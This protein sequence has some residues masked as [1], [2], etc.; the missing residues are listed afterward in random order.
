M[1]TF[2]VALTLEGPTGESARVDALVDTGST[3]AVIPASL[4]DRLGVLRR[5]RMSFRLADERMVDYDLGETVAD[6]DGRRMTVP[7]VFGPD[8]AEALLGA[9]TLEIFG[10]SADPVNQ[11]L[12]PVPGLLKGRR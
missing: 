2:T 5:D 3:Y 6:I 1:G 8:D 7:V 12:V 11:R 9:V 10:M 4:L